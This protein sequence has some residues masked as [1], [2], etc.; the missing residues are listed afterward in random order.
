M[1]GH[2]IVAARGAS[3]RRCAR[4]HHGDRDRSSASSGRAAQAARRAVPL[5]PRRMTVPVEAVRTPEGRQ[6]GHVAVSG[7][8]DGSAAHGDWPGV[9][10]RWHVD[11]HRERVRGAVRFVE[12]MIRLGA[13]AAPRAPAV[14]RGLPQLSSARCG[15]LTSGPV[16]DWC[17]PDWWPTVTPR[18]MTSF[19]ST[20]VIHCSWKSGQLGA[21]IERVDGGEDSDEH[22]LMRAVRASYG[23]WATV[24]SSRVA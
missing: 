22:R 6:C 23:A 7:V 21:E 15:P 4:R 17:W 14:V 20:G 9:D 24:H 5:S 2:R 3:P 16:P 8:P 11:D 19:I 12:E 13:D 10:R 1:I 18:C